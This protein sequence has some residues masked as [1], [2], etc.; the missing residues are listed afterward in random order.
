MGNLS[1]RKLDDEVMQ[2]LRIRAASKGLSMEEEVRRILKQ[3]VSGP[4]RLGDFALALFG[5]DH[6]IDLQLEKQKPAI[7]IDL[8][9]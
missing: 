2:R 9:E 5:P 4:E 1:V 8:S 7:P 3:A 6:G